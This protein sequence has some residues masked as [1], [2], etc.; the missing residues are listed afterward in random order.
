MI[1]KIVPVLRERVRAGRGPAPRA[2][3]A[4]ARRSAPPSGTTPAGRPRAGRAGWCS[5]Y[6]AH[7][8]RAGASALRRASSC[9]R[10]CSGP[11]IRK[12]IMARICRTLAVLLNAGIPLIEAMETVSR[13]TGNRV[14]EDALAAGHP[15]H[16][17]R[18]HDRRDAPPDRP[19][20]GHGDP[21]RGHGRGERHA[22]R[23][24]RQGRGL[25]RAAGRQHRGHAVDAD[26]ADHDRDHGR[27]RRRRHLRAVPAD[28]HAGPGDPG[29]GL[30][31]A[32]P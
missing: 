30:S 12:A 31:L 15:A 14:I 16:A 29:R 7:P 2:D 21:A 3:A 18:R 8:E 24:A 27:D 6:V 1:V 10:R 32:R 26:R 9:G 5:F 17:R 11:L 20:P 19:V 22:A 13:V 28:L 4:A 25:L 23:D